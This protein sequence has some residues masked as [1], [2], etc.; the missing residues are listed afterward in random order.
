MIRGV[1]PQRETGQTCANGR[2]EARGQR[3]RDAGVSAAERGCFLGEKVG[4]EAGEEAE[5]EAMEKED[6]RKG[7]GKTK[8]GRFEKRGFRSWSVGSG[9]QWLRLSS[10]GLDGVLLR[11]TSANHI[12]IYQ[13]PKLQTGL[14]DDEDA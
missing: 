11:S 8:V 9:D 7:K 4:A 1:D 6:E 13:V 5:E 14:R 3:P 12:C 2:S 10:K